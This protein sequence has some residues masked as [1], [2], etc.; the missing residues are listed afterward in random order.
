V[1]VVAADGDTA[2]TLLEP[3]ARNL[4]SVGVIDGGAA[5]ESADLVRGWPC[6]VAELGK[7]QRPPFDGPVD[8]RPYRRSPA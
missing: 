4:T 7:M 2:R 1:H 6:R 8:L 3:F 5:T